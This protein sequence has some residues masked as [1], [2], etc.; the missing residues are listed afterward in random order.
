MRYNFY[1]SLQIDDFLIKPIQRL[2]KYPNLL[3]RIMNFSKEA[4]LHDEAAS[5]E[6]AWKL[7][8]VSC[9]LMKVY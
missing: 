7:M 4:D 9:D 6:V 1:I 2:T 8:E 5:I 3:E